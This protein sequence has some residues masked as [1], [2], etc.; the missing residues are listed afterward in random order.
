[1]HTPSAGVLEATTAGQVLQ[2][3]GGV[4]TMSDPNDV[5]AVFTG[6]PSELGNALLA[7][8]SKLDAI[9]MTNLA[10]EE[11]SAVT[12]APLAVVRYL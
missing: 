11:P 3:N 8:F 12:K 6:S 4:A 5:G 7:S 2:A 1:M 9:D 10:F